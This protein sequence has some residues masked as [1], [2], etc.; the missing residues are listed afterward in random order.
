MLTNCGFLTPK[1]YDVNCGT[2][3][4]LTENHIPYFHSMLCQWAYNISLSFFWVVVISA[5]QKSHLMKS[6]LDVS[7]LEPSMRGKWEVTDRETNALFN[8][9]TQD[10]IGCIFA[11][12][13]RIPGETLDIRL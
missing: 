13:V 2:R 4:G 6:I 7:K 3:P 11:D 5:Q 10:T 8:E 12:S 1:W 9:Q